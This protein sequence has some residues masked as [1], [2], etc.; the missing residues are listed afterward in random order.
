MKHRSYVSF[1]ERHNTRWWIPRNRL[2]FWL[3]RKWGKGWLRATL[4]VEDSDD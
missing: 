4:D 3:W 2:T 1:S